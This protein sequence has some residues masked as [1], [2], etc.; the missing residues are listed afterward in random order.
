MTRRTIT[1]YPIAVTDTGHLLEQLYDDGET[2][3][4]LFC[5]GHGGDVEPGTAALGLELATGHE[6]AAYWAT[7][8]HESDGSAFDA[9][10][11]PSTAI[12]P[13]EYPLLGRIADRGFET[14]ISIHGLAD[15][16]ILVG[17]GLEEPTKTRVAR[18]LEDAVPVPV[19]VATDRQ[20]AG[21]HPDNFV[22]WLAADGAGLQLELGPTVRGSQAD[23]LERSLRSLLERDLL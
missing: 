12:D 6:T 1:T 11:P 5:A 10:H 4:L 17:G 2:D 8:G 23:A 3:E 13:A 9:W 16:E 20:Y 14:V 18:H 22:N 21:T 15:D 19:S 7:L